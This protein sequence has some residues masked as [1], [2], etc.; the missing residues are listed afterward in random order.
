MVMVAPVNV[1]VPN[2]GDLYD[3]PHTSLDTELFLQVQD[4]LNSF[5]YRPIALLSLMEIA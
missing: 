5:S 4:N 3:N 2:F 1:E